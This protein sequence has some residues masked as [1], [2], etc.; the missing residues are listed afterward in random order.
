MFRSNVPDNGLALKFFLIL[1]LITAKLSFLTADN[2][3]TAWV[4]FHNVKASPFRRE[5]RNILFNDS[6]T[7]R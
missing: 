2:R 7:V 3:A 4:S 1:F 6:S 5:Y